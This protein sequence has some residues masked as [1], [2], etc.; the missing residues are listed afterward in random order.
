MQLSVNC[1]LLGSVKCPYLSPENMLYFRMAD[2]INIF[3]RIGSS[4]LTAY[5]NYAISVH[6]SIFMH[7]NVTAEGLNGADVKGGY[8]I[9]A[10][11]HTFND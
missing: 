4:G 3:G 6:S 5:T 1:V 7:K 11:R 8:F 9:S 2:L 10:L